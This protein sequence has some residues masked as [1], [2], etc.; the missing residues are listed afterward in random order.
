MKMLLVLTLFVL[1]FIQTSQAQNASIVKNERATSVQLNAGLVSLRAPNQA[2]QAALGTTAQK[3]K[4]IIMDPECR[5]CLWNPW[6]IP[7]CWDVPCSG[8]TK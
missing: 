3:P 2:P 4:T 1:Y 7:I 6:G 8:S 5:R